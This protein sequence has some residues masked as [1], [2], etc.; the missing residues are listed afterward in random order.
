MCDKPGFKTP[1]PSRTQ[2]MRVVR[3]EVCLTTDRLTLP[4]KY[5]WLLVI[6]I[7]VDHHIEMAVVQ[8]A[9]SSPDSDQLWIVG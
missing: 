7:A 3:C 2:G 1:A 4:A 8:R 6:H 9:R 5:A